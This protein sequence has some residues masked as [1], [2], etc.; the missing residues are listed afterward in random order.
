MDRSRLVHDIMN[1]HPMGKKNT[2]LP[3]KSFLDTNIEIRM[4][5]EN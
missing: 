5:H 2:G 1:F 3:I 4:C